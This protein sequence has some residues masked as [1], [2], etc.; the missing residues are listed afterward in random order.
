MVV[1]AEDS[2]AAVRPAIRLETF[3]TGARVVKNMRCR[4]Q[5]QRLERPH[6]GL[7]PLTAIELRNHVVIAEFGSE[8]THW[9]PEMVR[10]RRGVTLPLVDDSL[11]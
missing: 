8:L 2:R 7:M 4:V 11:P 10:R 1:Q 3:E 5:M 6:L 9:C